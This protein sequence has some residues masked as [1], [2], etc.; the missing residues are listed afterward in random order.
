M[1]PGIIN[2]YENRS[3]EK[4][5]KQLDTIKVNDNKTDLTA[6]EKVVMKILELN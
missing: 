4:Y 6:E 5:I 3:L 1:H 2:M